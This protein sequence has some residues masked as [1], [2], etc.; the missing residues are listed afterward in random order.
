MATEVLT[1]NEVEIKQ[2]M[3]VLGLDNWVDDLLD[4]IEL[5]RELKISLE[6]A[7]RGELISREELKKR[8]DE[9]FANGYF[10]K[11]NAKKRIKE[12][13]GK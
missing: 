1:A 13:Y 9:K 3:G 6:Q 11:E 4:E 5:D 7:D 10:S 2:A 8:M 12:K